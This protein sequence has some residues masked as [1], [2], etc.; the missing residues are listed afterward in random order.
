M[1]DPAGQLKQLS[2]QLQLNLN[3]QNRDGE[4]AELPG[5]HGVAGNR[6][7]R[8]GVQNLV[9]DDQWKT[10]LKKRLANLTIICWPFMKRYGY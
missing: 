1:T 4:L 7:R 9:L 2:E 3:V 8:K 10:K 5:S 6:V